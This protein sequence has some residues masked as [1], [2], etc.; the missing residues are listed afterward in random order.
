VDY[1]CLASEFTKAILAQLHISAYLI[2]CSFSL[3]VLTQFFQLPGNL[4]Y[5]KYVTDLWYMNT[6]SENS[7]TFDMPYYHF[8]VLCRGK[9]GSPNISE[10]HV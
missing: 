4:K 9:S 10:V 1:D 5:K 8:E 2:K 7:I 6:V 3:D